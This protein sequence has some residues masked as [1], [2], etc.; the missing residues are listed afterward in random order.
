MSFC[1]RCPLS[2]TRQVS[3]RGPL[4]AKL[5]VIGEY[6]DKSA[7]YYNQAFH[8]GKP[9]KESPSV[10]IRRALSSIGLDPDKD[11]YW[12]YSLRCNPYKRAKSI[13]ASDIKSCNHNLNLELANV[14]APLVLV[15][16]PSAVQST[17]S[18]KGG[19]NGNRIGWHDIML[20]NRSRKAM[21]SLSINQIERNSLYTAEEQKGVDGTITVERGKR[22]NPFGSGPW[23]F[24]ND[25]F[26][27][28][29][30]LIE[31][32]II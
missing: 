29:A 3:G 30:K 31:M 23:F 24:R 5:I 26:K 2:S 32:G 6:P 7:E 18:T 20:G 25:M 14:T 13:K 21:V 27:L 19:V 10:T 22:W 28:K 11:V 16:G 9:G 17:I 4:N 1:T 12:V 15:L 8:P